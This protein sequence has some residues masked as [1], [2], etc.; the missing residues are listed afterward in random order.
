MW[1]GEEEVK[2]LNGYAYSKRTSGEKAR[3]EMHAHANLGQGSEDDREKKRMTKTWKA[4]GLHRGELSSLHIR[5]L[6][7]DSRALTNCI[8][9]R[10]FRCSRNVKRSKTMEN[11][12]DAVATSLAARFKSLGVAVS[13]QWVATCVAA[14]RSQPSK[15]GAR[16]GAAPARVEDLFQLCFAQFLHGDLRFG[17]NTRILYVVF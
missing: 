1:V 17:K 9:A 2:Q 16:G 5:S 8:F 15:F 11:G 7:S 14:I 4:G 13:P 10:V 3:V 6:R 12:G